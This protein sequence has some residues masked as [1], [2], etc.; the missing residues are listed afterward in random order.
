MPGALAGAL[1]LEL[2]H[3]FTAYVLVPYASAKEGTYGALGAAAA[4]LLGL[5]FVS[6]LIVGAAV[7]NATL[8]ERREA[9][10]AAG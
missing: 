2:I 6:R 8:W 9:N 7:L 4:L 5:F 3:V 10:R 1:G